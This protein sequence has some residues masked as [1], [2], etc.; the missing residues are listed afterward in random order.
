M[1]HVD[2]REIVVEAELKR[3]DVRA[4]IG[5]VERY[6]EIITRS[7]GDL[8][9]GA[10]Q[11]VMRRL[12]RQDAGRERVTLVPS[13]EST[14]GELVSLMD[15]LRRDASGPLFSEVALGEQQEASE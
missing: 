14:T 11:R 7:G 12:K 13:D 9:L 2:A 4:S 6:S 5:E 1:V 10:L 3:T 8:D 15:A